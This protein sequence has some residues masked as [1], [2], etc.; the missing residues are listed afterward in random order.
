SRPVPSGPYGVAQLEAWATVNGKTLPGAALKALVHGERLT[1]DDGKRVY[2]SGSEATWAVCHGLARTGVP[3]ELIVAAI[4]D[5]NN[6]GAEHV[7][8]QPRAQEY[9]W[10]QVAKVRAEQEAEAAV[11]PPVLHPKTPLRSARE[12][13]VREK[14]YFLHY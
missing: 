4:L 10:R 9:A 13:I 2:E 6:G 1:D 11:A 14:P 5:K 7:L 8:R 3:D 12:F